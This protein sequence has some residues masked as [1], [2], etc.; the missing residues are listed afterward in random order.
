MQTRPAPTAQPSNEQ[1]W[2]APGRFERELFFEAT[3]QTSHPGVG[4]FAAGA[5]AQGLHLRA[6]GKVAPRL[7]DASAACLLAHSLVIRAA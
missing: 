4:V 6:A 1:H 7:L 3:G 5:G 2:G